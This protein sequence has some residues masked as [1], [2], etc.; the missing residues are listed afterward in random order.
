MIPSRN[1][2]LKML[3]VLFLTFLFII[4][5]GFSLGAL[6]AMPLIRWA[7]HGVLYF[8]VASSELLSLLVVILG[9][10][11]VATVVTWLAGRY[12]GRW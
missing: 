3:G 4:G 11:V 10:T 8:P 12:K 7:I 9:V 2:G 1:L 6:L 5:M